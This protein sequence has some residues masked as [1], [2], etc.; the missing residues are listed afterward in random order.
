MSN[1]EFCKSW[2]NVDEPLWNATN[3]LQYYCYF[4]IGITFFIAFLVTEDT[5]KA[6]KPDSD[7]EQQDEIKEEEMSFRLTMLIFKDTLSNK[8]F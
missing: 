7:D 4:L 8:H 1:A 3:F 5:N 2:F 6:V